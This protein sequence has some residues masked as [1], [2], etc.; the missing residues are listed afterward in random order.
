MPRRVPNIAPVEPICVDFPT[1][2]EVIN[3]SLWTLRGYVAD[4]LIPTV[5]FP[6]S[7]HPGEKS[8]RRVLLV[9]DLRAFARKYRTTDPDLQTNPADHEADQPVTTASESQERKHRK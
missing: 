9:S 3:V 8:R 1:A 6:S 4:G 5:E 7:K 2:A